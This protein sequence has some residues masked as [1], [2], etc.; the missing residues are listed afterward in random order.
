MKIF[1]IAFCT[2]LFFCC[3]AQQNNKLFALDKDINPVGVIAT[4]TKNSVTLI[5]GKKLTY[6]AYTGYLNAKNDTGKLLAK[7]FFTYYKK[8]AEEPAKRPICFTFNGGPGS[9]SV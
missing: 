7:I 9:S 3:S 1:C 4:I 5:D 6:T 2:V 8:D